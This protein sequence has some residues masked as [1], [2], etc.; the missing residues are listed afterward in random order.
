VG[1]KARTPAI[2]ADNAGSSHTGE[3]KTLFRKSAQLNSLSKVAEDHPADSL[4]RQGYEAY[5][6]GK[7]KT[8]RQ[9]YQKAIALQPNN[10]DALLGLAALAVRAGRS[11]EAKQRYQRLLGAHPGDTAALAGLS[12]LEVEN[13]GSSLETNLK[14]AL[15]ANLQ[16]P[17]INF[18]LANLYSHQQRWAEAQTH[19][20]NAYRNDAQNPDLL[21]NLA[22]S[23]ENLGKVDVATRFYRLALTASESR[24]AAFD[25]DLLVRRLQSVQFSADGSEP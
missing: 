7:F 4:V 25:R 15:Q 19:Y 14:L 10:R 2:A 1:A 12:S 9:A 3:I 6:T 16:S 22:V 20:F 11:V 13:Q 18:A 24:N 23:L 5:Q 17:E 21:F 8:A